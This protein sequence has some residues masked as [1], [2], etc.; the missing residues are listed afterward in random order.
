MKCYNKNWILFSELAQYHLFK[1]H[2]DNQVHTYM[3]KMYVSM[4]TSLKFQATTA[5]I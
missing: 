5:A 3:C 2:T 1:L 4:V